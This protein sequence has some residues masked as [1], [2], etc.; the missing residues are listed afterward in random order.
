MRVG[1]ND[2][3]NFVDVFPQHLL[4]EIRAAIYRNGFSVDIY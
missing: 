4:A 3:I 1:E 2:A